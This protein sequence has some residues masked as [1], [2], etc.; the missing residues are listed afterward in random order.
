MS[1]DTGVDQVADAPEAPDVETTAREQGWT[2]QEEYKGNPARWKTAEEFV[3][4]GE[5]VNPIIKKQRDEFR[6]ALKA[7]ENKLEA[8]QRAVAQLLDFRTEEK[9]QEYEGQITFLKQQLKLARR[10]GE[11][12]TADVLEDQLEDLKAKKPDFTP[13]PVEQQP[14][15]MQPFVDWKSE[16]DW[17]ERDMPMTRQALGIAQELRIANP[18]LSGDAFFKAVSKELRKDFP[19]KFNKRLGMVEPAANSGIR[20]AAA[21]GSYARLPREAQN[22]CDEFVTAKLGTQAEYVKLYFGK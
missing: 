9:K 18:N 12:D 15:D 8:Q 14:M 17:F 2:P 11:E 4:F 21:S 10:Q 13:A 3:E 19:D 5:R 1:E 6:T 20:P 7:T 16:N 22:A